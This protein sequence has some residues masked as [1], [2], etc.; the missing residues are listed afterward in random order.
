[1]RKALVLAVVTF[2]VSGAALAAPATADTTDVTLT[3]SAGALSIDVSAATA[4]LTSGA[5]S[6]VLPSATVSASLGSTTV[7]DTRGTSTGWT[8]SVAATDFTS[9]AG[10]IAITNAT[11]APGAVAGLS[12]PTL[13]GVGGA[14]TFPT[15]V[16]LSTA[17]QQLGRCAHAVTSGGTVGANEVQWANTMSLTVPATAAPGTYTS[18]VTQSVQ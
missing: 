14:V 11:V 15:S 7:S 9:T 4:T 5:L 8:A 2:A 1:M 13:C 3:V 6:T 12:L 17:A 18:T 16:T 10:T